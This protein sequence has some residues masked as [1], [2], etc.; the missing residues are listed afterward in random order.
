MRKI[1]RRFRKLSQYYTGAEQIHHYRKFVPEGA[2]IPHLWV[3]G[4]EPT[5]LTLSPS[6]IATASRHFPT[7]TEEFS[8]RA[9]PTLVK[10]WDM[11][12]L[13]VV[14]L[15]LRIL[16]H[17][18]TIPLRHPRRKTV[19][20]I[21]CTR[22]CCWC[23]IQWIQRWNIHGR[24]CWTTSRRGGYSSH[25]SS[26]TGMSYNAD[27]FIVDQVNYVVD[28]VLERSTGHRLERPELK[29]SPSEEISY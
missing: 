20:L 8:E 23:C 13:P 7:L 5:T 19:R 9:Q 4:P 2:E 16:L 25:N 27:E 12:A 22:K 3:Q 18:E 15:E 26:L 28:N 21:G 11:T 6:P 10:Q 24:D 29:L 17:F 1:R 14:H